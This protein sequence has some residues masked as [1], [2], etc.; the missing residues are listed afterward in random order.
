MLA[1]NAAIPDICACAGAGKARGAQALP[2]QWYS[3]GTEE[4][5][6]VEPSAHTSLPLAPLTAEN[7]WWVPSGGGGTVFWVH[8]E[9]S[10]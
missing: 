7:T 4:P 1:D 2:S 9:P 8:A 10:Q 5:P 6:K 3:T